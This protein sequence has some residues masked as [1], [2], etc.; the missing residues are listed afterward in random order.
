MA[1]SVPHTWRQLECHLAGRGRIKGAPE[2]KRGCVAS[3]QSCRD[4][5]PTARHSPDSILLGRAAL[6]SAPLYLL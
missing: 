2:L 3:G 5:T 4:H 6:I 1:R